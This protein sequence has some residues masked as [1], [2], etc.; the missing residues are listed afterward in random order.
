MTVEGSEIEDRQASESLCF[1]VLEK[2][3]LSVDRGDAFIVLEP[4][5][6]SFTMSTT[7]DFSE[8][9]LPL[10]LAIGEWYDLLEQR[11]SKD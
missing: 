4:D 6:G 11:W 5:E 2:L 10:E 3:G 8:S 1:V 9:G 7:V